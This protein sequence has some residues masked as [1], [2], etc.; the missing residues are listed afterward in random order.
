MSLNIYPMSEEKEN[1]LNGIPGILPI[2]SEE[3]RMSMNSA[4]I[5]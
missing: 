3:K 4:I 1:K 5:F 2:R